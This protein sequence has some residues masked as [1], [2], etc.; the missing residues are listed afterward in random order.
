MASGSK[1][2]KGWEPVTGLPSTEAPYLFARRVGKAFDAGERKILALAPVS[3]EARKGEFIALTGPS[4]SGKSTLLNLL[5]GLERPTTGR[6]VV[7]GCDLGRTNDQA[8]AAMRNRQFGFMFQTPHA[9][10]GRSV[11]DNVALPLR[12]ARPDDDEVGQ[13]RVE[14]LLN[15][16][17]LDAFA[18]RLP[19]TLSGG[20]LQRLAFARALVMDPA[21][22]FADEP[23]ASLDDVNAN[24]LLSLLAEQARHGRLVIMA[25]HD[26]FARAFAFRE[27]RLQKVTDAL[28]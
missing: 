4:G 17:G 24:T 26:P 12:Y 19:A 28:A 20:E 1:C 18:G 13:K 27:L 15:Y 6:V 14:E 22:I 25:T 21:V 9:L 2:S 11:R 10:R 23:T 3:L 5:S 7:G 16:V 8:L